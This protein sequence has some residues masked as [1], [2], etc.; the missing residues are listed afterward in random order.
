[1]VWY[2]YKLVVYVGADVGEKPARPK[3]S[4]KPD[5]Q[6]LQDNDMNHSLLEQVTQVF[7]ILKVF[8]S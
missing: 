3:P 5:L 4:S 8:L 1:M 6:V 2:V 7:C